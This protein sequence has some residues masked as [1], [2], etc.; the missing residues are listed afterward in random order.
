MVLTLLAGMFAEIEH[1][2]RIGL[3][4][5]RDRLQFVG[6]IGS[7]GSIASSA[8][9]TPSSCGRCGASAACRA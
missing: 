7:R 9:S 4:R 1:L 5:Q 6:G 2:G 8:L 3:Q